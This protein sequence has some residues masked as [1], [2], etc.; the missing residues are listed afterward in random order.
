MKGRYE[1]FNNLKKANPN[2]KTLLAVGGNTNL[3]SDF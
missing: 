3:K 2:L 1:E